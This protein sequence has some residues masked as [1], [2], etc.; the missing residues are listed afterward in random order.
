LNQLGV[1]LLQV[2]ADDHDGWLPRTRWNHA[3][4]IESSISYTLV[5]HYQMSKELVTCPSAA[6]EGWGFAD[7][8]S[9][10]KW[11]YPDST[12]AMCYHYIG[13][14]GGHSPGSNIYHGWHEYFVDPIKPIVT[15]ALCEFPARNPF[16]WD[17]SYN[18]PDAVSHYAA[19]PPRSNHA[20]PDGT[21]VGEN[22]LFGDGHVEWR[23]LR[24][25]IG[26]YFGKDA[27]TK[28]YK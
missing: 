18:P 4:V 7:G 6:T 1:I 12:A 26:E 10:P 2:Y 17:T 19:L 20:N 15:T 5:D 14:H 11:L 13:G 8:V 22:M 16:M 3:Y 9:L 23:Q 25:G 21:A 28:F 24:L 27:A